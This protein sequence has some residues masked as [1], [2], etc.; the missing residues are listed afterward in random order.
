MSLQT[1]KNFE[2]GNVKSVNELVNV[3]SSVRV[4][5]ELIIIEVKFVIF[6]LE[7]SL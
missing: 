4:N 1:N 2:F 7:K 6:L 3:A 5:I